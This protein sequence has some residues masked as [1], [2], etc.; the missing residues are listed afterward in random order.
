VLARVA[1]GPLF[2]DKPDLLAALTLAR[3]GVQRHV[4]NAARETVRY[5]SI[6]D[7]GAVGWVRVGSGEC[8]WCRQYLDG[9]VHDVEG[10][11]FDAHD[12]CGCTAEP[13]FRT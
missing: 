8:D 2:G 13:V 12:H 7:R 11:D 4:A 3:G 1:V 10:Y 5:S 9:V 6:Q